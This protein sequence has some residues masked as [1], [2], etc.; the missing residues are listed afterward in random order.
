MAL[1]NTYTAEDG[2]TLTA[3]YRIREVHTQYEKDRGDTA[4]KAIHFSVEAFDNSTNEQLFEPVE[5]REANEIKWH[6]MNAGDQ[7]VDV[8]IDKAYAQLKTL[9]HFSEAEDC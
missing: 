8:L 5:V 6:S 7:T 2:S 3:Y 9:A 1:R 4:D